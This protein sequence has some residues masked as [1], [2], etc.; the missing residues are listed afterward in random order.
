[1]KRQRSRHTVFSSISDEKLALIIAE[2]Y[3][4][5]P[6]EFSCGKTDVISDSAEFLSNTSARGIN[7][8]KKWL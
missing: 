1:M 2:D 7:P 3:K 8:M 5:S 6:G 4:N